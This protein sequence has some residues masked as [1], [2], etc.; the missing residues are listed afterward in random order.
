M[1]LKLSILAVIIAFIS[2]SFAFAQQDKSKRPSPPDSVH[3]TTKDGVHVAI[4]YS[5]P[6][7]KGR[8]LGVD[9]AK[10]GEVWRTGA[11]EITTISF[12]K[13]VLIEGQ[14]LP[15]G[16]YGLWTIPGETETTVIFSK[17]W[18]GWGVGYSDKEDQLRVKVIPTLGNPS[19]EQFTISVD[20]AGKIN[21]AWGEII[22]PIKV[23]MAK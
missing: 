23:K 21:L 14:A 17:K 12:D 9:L 13:D 5:K 10:I 20:P 7:L 1:R 19:V 18:K 16:K 4:N 15:K 8:Q 6:S 22:I 3:I 2:T 11:N